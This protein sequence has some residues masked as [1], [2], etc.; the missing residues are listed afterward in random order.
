MKDGGGKWIDRAYEGI[1]PWW[2]RSFHQGK[3]EGETHM[4]RKSGKVVPFRPRQRRFKIIKFLFVFT[5]LVL[6][7]YM[8]LLC[9]PVFTIRV[10]EVTGNERLS[11]EDI[12]RLAALEPGSNILHLKP[13]QVEEWIR[14]SPWV[15]EAT[16]K[17]LLTGT[18]IIQVKERTPA[19]LVPYYTSFLLLAGD[20]VILGPAPHDLIKD[21]ELP[22]L[23]GLELTDPVTS[24]ESV[25]D[26]RLDNLVRAMASFPSPFW[27]EVAEFHLTPDGEVV[28]YTKDGVQI[29]FGQASHVPEKIQLIERTCQEVLDPIETI[30]VRSGKRVHVR[31]REF[32]TGGEGT[33]ALV[34][35]K[36]EVK[37]RENSSGVEFN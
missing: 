21:I 5:A 22:V 35:A 2:P 4:G 27:Q 1:R 6:A 11:H 25:G 14:T 26:Q 15:K 34:A 13:R 29:L 17:R 33:T 18:V 20:G 31:L 16:V 7:V 32:A 23:T 9:Y 8:I 37:E 28:I 3:L 10:I 36:K 24:G 19:F 12:M 30:N